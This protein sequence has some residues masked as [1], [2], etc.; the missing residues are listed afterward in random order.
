MFTWF[1]QILPELRLRVHIACQATTAGIRPDFIVSINIL[2]QLD[3]LLVDYV[4]RFMKISEEDKAV[5]RKRIQQ[6]HIELLNADLPKGVHH[7]EWY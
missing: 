7:E 5:F 1:R 6:Q 3:I 4:S 2:N